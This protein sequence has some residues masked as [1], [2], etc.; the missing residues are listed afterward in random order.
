MSQLRV[1]ITAMKGDLQSSSLPQLN[2][3]NDGLCYVALSLVDL[4]L[5]SYKVKSAPR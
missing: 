4:S 3:V 2:Y 1:K 5:T